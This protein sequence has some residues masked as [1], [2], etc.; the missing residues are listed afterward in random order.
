MM[1]LIYDLI[2]IYEKY[3]IIPYINKMY[4]NE[5]NSKIRLV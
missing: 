4:T 2:M 1:A 3:M 5:K